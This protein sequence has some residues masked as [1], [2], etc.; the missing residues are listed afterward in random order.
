MVG[1]HNATTPYHTITPKGVGWV[2]GFCLGFSLGTCCRI[3]LGPPIH[4]ILIPDPLH[5]YKRCWHPLYAV[6]GR[7]DATPYHTITLK[8]VGSGLSSS[9]RSGVKILKCIY[10]WVMIRSSHPLHTHTRSTL[11]IYNVFDMLNMWWAVIEYVLTPL[12]LVPP[13]VA[14]G[15]VRALVFDMYYTVM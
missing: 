15:L 6:G 2:I 8:R 7:K 10:C 1:S 11:Y 12:V 3:W 9:R 13:W 14:S 4:F 5:T